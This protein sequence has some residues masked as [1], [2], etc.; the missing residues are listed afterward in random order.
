MRAR[1]PDRTGYV[2]QDGVR[3]YYEVFGDGPLTMLMMGTFPVVDGRQWKAQVPYLA[4]TYRVVTFDPRGNGRSDRPVGSAAYADE[5]YARDAAAV[6]DATTAGPAFVVALCSGIKW[7]LLLALERPEQI[8]GLVAI[9]P[10][11]HPLAPSDGLL[12][13]VDHPEWEGD[14]P[15]WIDYHSEA[16][17]PEP[18]SSKPF[19]DLVAWTAQTDADTLTARVHAPLRPSEEDEAVAMC[20]AL[21]RPVLV[22]HGTADRCQPLA[23]GRRFAEL[24][25]GRLVELDGVGHLPHARHPVRVNTLIKEFVDMHTAPEPRRT[26]WLFARDRPRRA[27]WMCSPIGLGHVLRDLAIARAL[28]ELV[29]DLEIH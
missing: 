3:T 4:R 18:H 6:L 14:F 27:L 20:T 19:E 22:I 11:V 12:E 28:R 10:G 8:R 15:R 5:V 25:G 23:R 16:L 24:T 1:E 2:T 7:S 13:P 17:L 29:P 26:A 21:N 9:A